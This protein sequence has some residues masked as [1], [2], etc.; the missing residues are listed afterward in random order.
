MKS[1]TSLK[2]GGTSKK[3]CMSV[4]NKR[5][6]SWRRLTLRSHQMSLNGWLISS[7]KQPSMTPNSTSTSSKSSSKREYQ[8]RYKIESVPSNKNEMKF[9]SKCFIHAGKIKEKTAKTDHS[10]VTSGTT[11]TLLV[12]ITT[13]LSNRWKLRIRHLSEV[14]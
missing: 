12:K 2:S 1:K 4:P 9:S 13:Q 10:S 8:S 7:R 3:K 6:R 11:K 5:Y 14:K